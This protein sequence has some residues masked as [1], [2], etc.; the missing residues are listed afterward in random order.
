MDKIKE[1]PRGSS[2]VREKGV[3]AV[4]RGLEGG[5]DR[6]RTQLRDAAQQGQRDEYGGDQ[7]EDAA[8]CAPGRVVRAAEG[9]ARGRKHPDRDQTR[10]GYTEPEAP[11]GTSG[12]TV[13]PRIKTRA[14]A[15]D[16]TGSFSSSAEGP[17]RPAQ[18]PQAQPGCT[19]AGDKGEVSPPG[20]E[21]RPAIKTKGRYIREQTPT[22]VTH[23]P[24]DR[25][26]GTEVFIQERGQKMAADGAGENM[27]YR[28]NREPLSPALNPEPQA[29]TGDGP[30]PAR[31]KADGPKAGEKRSTGT[32]RAAGWTAKQSP[33]TGERSSASLPGQAGKPAAH[34][35]NSRPALIRT[36]GADRAGR[37]AV[38]TLERSRP[39][40]GNPAGASGRA[41]RT[42]QA[43]QAARRT[44][45]SGRTA[46]RTGRRARRAARQ[47]QRGAKAAWTAA[48]G[49]LALLAASPVVLAVV[50]LICIVGLVVASPFGIFFSGE[51]SGTGQ[52]IRTAIQEINQDYQARLDELRAS[53]AYDVVE[54]SG[55]RAVWKEV[56]AVY[57]VRTTTDPDNAQEVVTTDEDKRQIL[58]D[59]FWEMNQIS[60]TTETRTETVVE[61]TDDGSGNL[62]ETEVTVTR[63]YLLI[64]VRHKTAQEMAD[65]Y[66]FDQEQRDQLAELLSEENDALWREALY[67]I[68][69][70]EGDLVAVALSQVGNV[71]GQ[72][73]WSWYGFDSRVDW[74][75][76]FVSWCAEQCGYLEIGV[77]PRFAGCIQGSNWF[78][79]RG[80]WQDG[81]YEPRPGDIIFFDWEGDG[82]PDHVGI[83]EKVENGQIHTAEGN[84]GD[85]C[86][87]NSYPVGSSVVYGY[88]CPAY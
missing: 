13:P 34:P 30:S 3:D 61:V 45:G 2:A 21:G 23:Q 64:T 67:G 70:E 32:P 62:A 48:R 20:Q 84:S 33:A 83:V 53:A 85:M 60:H 59:I 4:R 40:V 36:R 69:G 52:T 8:A 35:G 17:D 22:P 71:G 66:A 39:A 78:K 79:S 31:G 26:Q 82:L 87:Q 86:R 27:A 65:Y 58:E 57:A 54:V 80:L 88:G 14:A 25:S 72:P 50:V 1:K 81:S 63:A 75:A 29:E 12:D 24:H 28:T 7:I 9:L 15:A 44:M 37:P 5:A 68:T 43:S 49:G 42:V 16:R 41:A 18:P 51:D 73:Y 55:S 46:A 10:R 47:V 74:C 77:I 11:K 38:K 6:L 76:C 19:S 56:L